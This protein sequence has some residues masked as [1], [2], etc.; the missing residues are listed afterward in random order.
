M[1]VSTRD[2]VY[3][4]DTDDDDCIALLLDDVPSSDTLLELI[5][6]SCDSVVEV[7]D[8]TRVAEEEEAIDDDDC[9]TLLVEVSVLATDELVDAEVR[10]LDESDI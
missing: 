5:P 4:E 10:L 1:E 8:S 3:E 6:P 2:D 7:E 9:K